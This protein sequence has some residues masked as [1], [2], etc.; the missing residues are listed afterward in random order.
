MEKIKKI[1]KIE[2]DILLLLIKK[3]ATNIEQIAAITSYNM[4]D[5]QEAAQK[6]IQKGFIVG[7]GGLDNV[8]NND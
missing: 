8:G 2:E 6:L 1:S 4:N 7:I 5:I 3:K